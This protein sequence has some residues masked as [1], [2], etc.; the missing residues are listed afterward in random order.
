[1]RTAH[2]KQVMDSLEEVVAPGHTALLML[3]MI[4]DF[5]SPGGKLFNPNA[6][7]LDQ[8]LAIIPRTAQLLE[9][10]RKA[11]A[12]PVYVQNTFLPKG[13]DLP[14]GYLYFL[15]KRGV[16]LGEPLPT[17]EGTWGAETIP[18]L[19][20]REGEPV[21][22]KRSYSGFLDT[23]LD[24][25]LK[26]HDVKTIVVTGASSYG[27]IVTTA[28]EGFCYGYYVA[29]P[30]ECTAGTIRDWHQAAMTLMSPLVVDYED[31]LK[32]WQKSA[33]Y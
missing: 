29:V 27:C 20:P 4:N 17:L 16:T 14:A 23:R 22:T 18:Q 15:F 19:K 25:V 33:G 6:T 9:A 30:R 28:L 26:A 5:L 7:D 31:V 8:V 10:A 3:D 2:G 21:I 24:A 11:G 1:M 12:L 13:A 32:V